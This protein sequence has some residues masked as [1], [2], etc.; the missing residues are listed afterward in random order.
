MKLTGAVL[1]AHHLLQARLPQAAVIV[2]ATAGNGKDTLFLARHANQKASFWIFDIQEKALMATKNLLVAKDIMINGTYIHDCHSKLDRY[3]SE[4]IDIITFNLG[5][6]PGSDHTIS[7]QPSTTI[8]A[9]EAATAL[10]APGGI[11][12]VVTY[13]GYQIGYQE[14]CL[15]KEFLPS[16]PQQQY[17]VACWEMVNQIH[18]PPI[19]YA[20]ER[21]E[22]SS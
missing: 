6:L 15:I 21:R 18:N 20:I 2:D 22:G 8:K 14:H 3:I 7:T 11:I 12:T 16:L 19:L 10:L 17:T 4:P 5:Y 13:P 9:L 1:M